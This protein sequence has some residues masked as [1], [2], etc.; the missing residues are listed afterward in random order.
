MFGVGG[1]LLVPTTDTHPDTRPDASPA[2]PDEAELFQR[3][4]GDP[5]PQ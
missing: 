1:A 2:L 5:P 3:I 4:F